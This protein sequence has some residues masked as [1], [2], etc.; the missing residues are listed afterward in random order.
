MKKFVRDKLRKK[1]KVKLAF[2][3]LGKTPEQIAEIRKKNR[4][5][6][7][8]KAEYIEKLDKIGFKFHEHKYILP[9]GDEFSYVGPINDDLNHYLSMLSKKDSNMKRNIK[10]F[11]IKVENCVKSVNKCLDKCTRS[12]IQLHHLLLWIPTLLTLYFFVLNMTVN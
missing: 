2:R 9:N 12:T 4:E 10:T 8:Q 7:I 3:D 5:K 11:R 6:E 1:I